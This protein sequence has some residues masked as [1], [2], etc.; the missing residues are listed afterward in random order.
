MITQLLQAH[1]RS[2]KP[3]RRAPKCKLRAITGNWPESLFC[4]VAAKISADHF[5][6]SFSDLTADTRRSPKVARARQVAMYL[7]HVA[8]GIPLAEVGSCFGRDRT[9]VSHACNRIEDG[10]D[11]PAFDADL[12]E[13]EIAASIMR[14]LHNREVFS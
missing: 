10:R 14:D 1:P 2:S 11:E 5:E 4:K 3:R 9:T 7:A 6:V 13:M 8:F 12:M